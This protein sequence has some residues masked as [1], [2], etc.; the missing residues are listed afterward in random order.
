MLNEPRSP[1]GPLSLY[2]HVHAQE[3]R[4]YKTPR[5]V[6]RCALGPRIR[7][8]HWFGAA[9]GAER[10]GATR[11]SVRVPLPVYESAAAEKKLK[12]IIDAAM[13]DGNIDEKE[14]KQIDDAKRELEKIGGSKVRYGW[15]SWGREDEVMGEKEWREEVGVGFSL[16][17]GPKLSEGLR[18]RI[19]LELL[20]KTLAS[21]SYLKVHPRY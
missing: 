14:Q 13:E 16:E 2:E 7:N 6:E 4:G 17:E 1:A 5:N 21:V 3:I 12:E 18:V 10:A 9:V 8:Q 19:F 20:G 11:A 15:K